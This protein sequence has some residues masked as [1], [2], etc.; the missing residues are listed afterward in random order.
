MMQIHKNLPFIITFLILHEDKLHASETLCQ[1]SCEEGSPPRICYY[2]FELEL[3][4]TMSKACFNC[5][6]NQSDCSL[7]HC[8]A[9][10]GVEKAVVV[11]NRQLPGP[12]IQVCEGDTI[13]VDLKNLLSDASTSIHWHG[14][15]QKNTPYMDGVSMVTQCPIPSSTT[16]RYSFDAVNPGTHFWH[17]HSGLQNVDGAHGTLIVR[18][19]SKREPHFNLYDEDL[20]EHVIIITDWLNTFS[21]TK[22]AAHHHSDG[23]N[24]A[25]SFLIN[26]KGRY[27]A[28]LDD[29]DGKV[30]TPVETFHVKYG[31][32][33]RFRVVGNGFLNCPF[34]LSI[35]DHSIKVIASD[36]SP[37]KPVD[38]ESIVIYSGERFDFILKANQKVKNYWMRI[39]GLLDCGANFTSAY[40]MAVIKYD[41]AKEK[42]LNEAGD[43]KNMKRTGKQLNSLNTPSN[44]TTISVADLTAL[45]SEDWPL[46]AQPSHQFHL[47]FDFNAID[48]PHFHDPRYY[49]FFDPRLKANERLYTPQINGITF[50][51]PSS[52]LL[53][54][55]GTYD[56]CNET[57]VQRNCSNQFCSC[58]YVYE[59]PLYSLVEL[60]LVDN[61]YTFDANHPFHLHGHAF[62][63]VAM[64]KVADSISLE[65]V[66]QMDADGKIRRKLSHAPIKDSITV[67]DGGYVVVRFVA[68]NPGFWLLHCH[69]SFHMELGMA[70]VFKVGTRR[71][72]APIPEDF[73]KCGDW[74]PKLSLESNVANEIALKQSLI[75]A[76]SLLILLHIFY[77]HS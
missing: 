42:V 43:Y 30:F 38:V 65:T 51:M 52:P 13:I 54:Q 31:K 1:R 76:M 56:F 26:G 4:Y 66:K 45:K 23:N 59:I 77:Y 17:S 19:S 41:G 71:E 58:V 25:E 57:T 50:K 2:V 16:F 8:V 73:P 40:Q 34:E 60:I 68:D 14:L 28:F 27:R 53:T 55:I 6:F 37:I 74:T 44:N 63:V 72:F 36:G 10:N 22:F 12:S 32:N 3:Y 75:Y 69:I 46:D 67:P 35:D 33:Y 47:A 7:P 62:R 5:P 21:A 24:K 39:R 18:Q 48:N 9:A 61:G 64:D 20:P 49:S 11:V 15:H 29:D 70:V